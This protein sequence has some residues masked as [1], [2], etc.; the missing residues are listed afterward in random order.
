MNQGNVFFS[1]AVELFEMN[2]L[3]DQQENKRRSVV[4]SIIQQSTISSITTIKTCQINLLA[5]IASAY[6]F[7]YFANTS[8]GLSCVC[9]LISHICL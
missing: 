3:L 1:H 9:S 5:R 4:N 8:F 2:R 7:L 6:F